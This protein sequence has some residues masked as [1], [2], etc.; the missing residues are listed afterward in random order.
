[1]TRKPWA[2]W[3]FRLPRRG[4]RQ[5][6]VADGE[7]EITYGENQMASEPWPEVAD[8]EVALMASEFLWGAPIVDDAV[9]A[10]LAAWRADHAD[11]LSKGPEAVMEEVAASNAEFDR[12]LEAERELER[13]EDA[14]QDRLRQEQADRELKWFVRQADAE[15]EPEP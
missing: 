8:H 4:P 1:V 11:L 14:E 9:A 5:P 7:Q 2:G 12:E 10:E 13:E 15:R 6:A 3:K